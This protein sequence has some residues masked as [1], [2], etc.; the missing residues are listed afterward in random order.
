MGFPVDN[1][2]SV[3]LDASGNGTVKVGP[4]NSGQL[5][6]ITRASVQVSSNTK[7]PTANLWLGNKAKFISGTYTG[8]NDTDDALNEY[9]GGTG[10]IMCIWTGGDPGA[11]ATLTIA[12]EQGP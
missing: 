9:L 2:K 8:S 12:G 3:T 1:N 4:T 7:E 10:Y 5:W 6:H 11:T